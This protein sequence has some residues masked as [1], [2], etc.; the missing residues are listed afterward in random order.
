MIIDKYF[1]YSLTT[2]SALSVLTSKGI[3]H[4]DLKP[5]NILLSY[6]SSTG[7]PQPSDI[8]IKIGKKLN[9]NSYY[10]KVESCIFS[11]NT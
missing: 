2:A 4:R 8:E 3:V 5:Q 9:M 11:E 7:Q 6:G 10:M 1:F